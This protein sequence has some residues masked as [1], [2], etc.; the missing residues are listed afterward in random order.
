[1][2][3][4]AVKAKAAAPVRGKSPFH[5]MTRPSRQA[6]QRFIP[7]KDRA[8]PLPAGQEQRKTTA[9]QQPLAT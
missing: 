8:S 3:P 2:L 5:G 7:G 9:R 1:V 6:L 4:P